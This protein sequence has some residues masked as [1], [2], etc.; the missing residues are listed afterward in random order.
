MKRANK[1]TPSMA[2]ISIN[3]KCRTKGLTYLP[4]KQ[5]L[6]LPAQEKRTNYKTGSFVTYI[7]IVTISSHNLNAKPN[8]DI[9]LHSK[10]QNKKQ[11]VGVQ[12]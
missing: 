8:K 11:D 2:V 6:S 7:N 10:I 12:S 3:R 5:A 4:K 9:I 1:M